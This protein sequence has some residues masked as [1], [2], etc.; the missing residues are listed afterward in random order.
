MAIWKLYPLFQVIKIS[1]AEYPTNVLTE[2]AATPWLVSHR[3]LVS[4]I[5]CVSN[6]EMGAVEEAISHHS[7]QNGRNARDRAAKRRMEAGLS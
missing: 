7:S 3:W 4:G 1:L 5:L 2:N 6:L